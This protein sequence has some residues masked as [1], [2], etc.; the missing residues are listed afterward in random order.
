MPL[1]HAYIAFVANNPN[2]A[3]LSIASLLLCWFG[4]GWCL[5]VL[6]VEWHFSRIG[7][8]MRTAIGLHVGACNLY[9]AREIRYT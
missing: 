6:V 1:L 8:I 4:I 5:R 3:A 7:V 2:V 9:F